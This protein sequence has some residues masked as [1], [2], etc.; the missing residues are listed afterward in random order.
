MSFGPRTLVRAASAVRP[1]SGVPS[2]AVITSP[3]TQARLLG[4]RAGERPDDREPAAVAQGRAGGGLA[5]PV[6][7]PDRRP[8]PLELAGDALERGL[9]LVGGHVQGIRVVEGADHALDRAFDQRLLVDRP[10]RVAVRDRRVGV[11]ERLERVRRARRGARGQRG[12]AAERE[13]GDEQGAAGEDGDDA[14][15]A[16]QDPEI[17]ADPG[18]GP[19]RGGRRGRLQRGRGRIQR[20]PGRPYPRSR[21]RRLAPGGPATRVRGSWGF[22]GVTGAGRKRGP[23]AYNCDAKSSGASQPGIRA[24]GAT[25]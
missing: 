15:R 12:L 6:H 24:A 11:P 19:R 3:G 25:G 1:A 4:G 10:T 17:R 14:E 2:I 20:R 9:E 23:S 18:A 22:R 7:R 5:R 8:D 13:P 21:Q 16:D